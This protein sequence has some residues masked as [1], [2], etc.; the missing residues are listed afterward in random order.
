MSL[1]RQNP[2]DPIASPKSHFG[3]WQWGVS[4]QLIKNIS[5]PSQVLGKWLLLQP[6]SGM[7]FL[8]FLREP[9]HPAGYLGHESYS[10]L[11]VRRPEEL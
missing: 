3:T 7:A 8:P 11:G 4:L 6:V 9:G 5:Y 10:R 2:C 1:M